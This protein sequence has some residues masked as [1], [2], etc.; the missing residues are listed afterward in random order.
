MAD[1]TKEELQ[2][3]QVLAFHCVRGPWKCRRSGSAWTVLTHLG[4]TVCET[5]FGSVATLL[6]DCPPEVI[7]A[8]TEEILR[9]RDEIAELEQARHCEWMGLEDVIRE[10]DKLER[11]R[12]FLAKML[13][14]EGKRCPAD[15]PE[16]EAWQIARADC[17]ADAL[18]K[19]DCSRRCASDCWKDTAIK[20]VEGN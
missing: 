20:A 19:Q 1:L 12:N 6:A 3:L 5:D 14:S 9:L 4:A 11:E 16:S 15:F 13:A 2:S 17:E 10:R 7:Y 18:T 8:M